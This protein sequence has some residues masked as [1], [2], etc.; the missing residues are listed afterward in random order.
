MEHDL[1]T[2]I[3]IEAPPEHVWAILTDLDAW[4]EWNPFITSSEGTVAVG[5]KLANRMEPPG[6]KA[7]TFKPTVTVVEPATTFEWLGRLVLPGVFDGRHRFELEATESG[8]THLVHSEQLNGVLVRFMRKSLDNQTLAG[9]EA[10]NAALKTRAE[11][12]EP[13]SG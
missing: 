12:G 11:S 4:P 8:G 6:G 5:E 10:M 7:I 2:E 9:F 3:D 1:H 13:T